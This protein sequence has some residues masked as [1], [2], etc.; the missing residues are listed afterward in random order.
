MN[1]ICSYTRSASNRSLDTRQGLS[2]MLLLTAVGGSESNGCGSIGTAL[3]AVGV[4]AKGRF[5]GRRD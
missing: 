3:S 1:G 4:A 2:N 5:D